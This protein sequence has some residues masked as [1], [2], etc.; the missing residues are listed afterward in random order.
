[1]KVFR[2]AILRP[3]VTDPCPGPGLRQGPHSSGRDLASGMGGVY[4]IGFCFSHL[5]RQK[6]GLLLLLL[7]FWSSLGFQTKTVPGSL[8]P[9]SLVTLQGSGK[10]KVRPTIPL[11][12][13]LSELVVCT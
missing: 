1:M 7:T 4:P 5:P 9:F 13:H 8:T 2:A 11:I 12:V 10:T 3:H 6:L